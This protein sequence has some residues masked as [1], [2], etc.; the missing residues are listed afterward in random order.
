MVRRV[1]AAL[2]STLSFIDR[3]NSAVGFGAGL[4]VLSL[5]GVTVYEVVSRY[6][7]HRPTSWSFEVSTYMLVACVFLAAA[8]THLMEGHVRVDIVLSRLSHKT[9]SLM[10]IATSILALIFVAIL[11]WESWDVA[12]SALQGGW[13]SDS[14]IALPL[15]PA[16][17]TIPIGGFLLCLQ[18]VS[19]LWVYTESLLTEHSQRKAK[20]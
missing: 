9:Q 20:A 1:K 5:T 4:I 2:K 10:N 12:W 7:F 14:P 13:R 19:K 3:S 16:K 18:I 11:T 15:F 6:L 8:R 17:V